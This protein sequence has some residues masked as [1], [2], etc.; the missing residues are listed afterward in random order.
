MSQGFTKGTPIDTDPTLSLNSDIVVPSQK[1]V[2]SYLTANY[3]PTLVSGT[4]IKTINGNTLLGSGDLTIGG[5]GLT[6]G[7]TAI[8]SG[9]IGRILF[10]NGGDVLGQDSALFWDNTNKRLGIGATPA[11]T[12]RLDVRAQGALSTDIVQ[13]WRNSADTAN[14]GIVTGDGAFTIGTYTNPSTQLSINSSLNFGLY[15]AGITGIYAQNQQGSGSRYGIQSLGRSNVVGATAYGI[16]TGADS[17]SAST[18]NYGIQAYAYNGTTNYAGYFDATG[19]TN[20]YALVTQ[21]GFSGFNKTDPAAIVDIKAAGALSTDIAFRVRN[22]ADNKN[23]VEVR[24]DGETRWNGLPA[25]GNYVAI[26]NYTSYDA[27]IDLMGGNSV[28]AQISMDIASNLNINRGLNIWNPGIVGQS[29]SKINNIVKSGLAAYGAGYG[30]NW[31]FTS[32]ASGIFTQSERALWLTSTKSMVLYNGSSI[33]DTHSEKA[34]SFEM[35]SSDIVAGNAAPHFRTEVGDV[36]KLYKE[37]TAITAS[38]LVSN[39]GMPLTDTDTFDGYTLK[40]VVKALRNLG[41][42]A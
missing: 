9:T 17:S 27:T 25:V 12:V 5:G 41:L 35:Y 16:R 18:I 31:A 7:T 20:N 3:Q 14:L 26:K 38:T 32:N 15:V 40:Q 33:T 4:N 37:T 36:I 24:G 11:S 8:A 6:V 34:D 28:K 22:S 21:R 13:R 23:I 30:F 39:L 1:A 10:Q 2:K 19:G 42:L 29:T